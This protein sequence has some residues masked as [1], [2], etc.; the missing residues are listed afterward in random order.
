M[1]KVMLHNHTWY[2]TFVLPELTTTERVNFTLCADPEQYIVIKRFRNPYDKGI[3]QN[4]KE[5]F[6]LTPKQ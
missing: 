6:C 1:V 5:F 4:V 3:L 2:V